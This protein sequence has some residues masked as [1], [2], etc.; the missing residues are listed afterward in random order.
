MELVTAGDLPASRAVELEYFSTLYARQAQESTA[1]VVT[2]HGEGRVIATPA[3]M[4]ML[5]EW[6]RLVYD[7]V[8]S[9]RSGAAWSLAFS[10]HREG[11]IAGF[12]DDI[13]VYLTGEAVVTSCKSEEG[14]ALGRVRLDSQQ[15]ADLYT[16]VDS[17]APFEIEQ[18]DPATADAMTIHLV[19]NG[20][21]TAEASAHDQSGLIQ[22]ASELVLQA[23]TP[24]D[25]TA[26]AAAEQALV[27]YLA[28]LA[29][30]DY[31]GA[32]A[33]YGGNYGLL[34]DNNPSLDPGDHAALFTHACTIN[35]HVCDLSIRNVVSVAGLGAGSYRFMVELQNPQGVLFELGQCCTDASD[36][37]PPHTQFAFLVE[38][39][40]GRYLVM[41]LPIYAG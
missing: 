10:W 27:D 9:G 14:Q 40:D 30:A 26:Q 41:T 29:A 1:G 6:A 8:S 35:G 2:W 32:A 15:L 33:L 39:V 16:W 17:L 31:A 38:L 34:I 3:E 25:P 23:G 28:A 20:Q 19:F 5:A 11:G 18:T 7:E 37:T 24:A 13:G 12:C 22:L 21:G 36:G 4:R